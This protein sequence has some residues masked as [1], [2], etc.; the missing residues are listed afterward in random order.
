M[1]DT[2]GVLTR[3]EAEMLNGAEVW[4][5]VSITAISPRGA[6]R[7]T[8]LATRDDG[9]SRSLSGND[10]GRAQTTGRARNEALQVAGRFGPT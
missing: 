10:R 6:T 2:S 9:A 4:N 7:E 1:K 5:G 3:E 8:T